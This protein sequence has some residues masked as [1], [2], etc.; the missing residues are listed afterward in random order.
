MAAPAALTQRFDYATTYH[1]YSI[2]WTSLGSPSSPP[3][4]FIHGTPWSSRVW[5]PFALSLSRYYHVYLFDNPGFGESPLG[6]HLPSKESEITAKI[7]LDAD[8][9]EQSAAFAGLFDSWATSD[10]EGWKGRTAHVVAHDHGGLM[11]LRA[12]LLHGCEYASLCLIDVVAIG[13]FGQPLFKL[14]AENEGVFKQLTGPVFEGV[15]ES[16]IRDAA[17][18]SLSTEVMQMLKGPWLRNKE[19]REGFVRQMCQANSRS[20]D[21]VEGQYGLVGERVPVKIIWGRDDKW[22]PA[23]TADRLA[24][25]LNAKE[26]VVIGEAGHLIM[27][28]QGERLGVE[29]GWWLKS[30]T[31]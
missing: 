23:Q 4:I 11:A 27:Y 31:P 8:L 7:A 2:R 28:D 6:K 10:R 1:E 30:V 21:E 5:V 24:Q 16:Y 13:P 3:L 29:L 22:I 20:T 26:V 12:H 18:R 17:H 19:G 15:V 9:A 25:A 14:V